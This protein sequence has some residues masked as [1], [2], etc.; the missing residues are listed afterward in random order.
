MIKK[1]IFLF[2]VLFLVSCGTKEETQDVSDYNESDVVL[3]EPEPVANITTEIPKVEEKPKEDL[4]KKEAE[5]A[6]ANFKDRYREAQKQLKDYESN[7]TD[8]AK[9]YMESSKDLLDQAEK[10]FEK[11][12]YEKSI[13]YSS[14]ALDLLEIKF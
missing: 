3:S 9:S 1:L 12:N 5:E 13:E 8:V 11:G 10:E 6:L 7:E 4:K 2:L 14:G